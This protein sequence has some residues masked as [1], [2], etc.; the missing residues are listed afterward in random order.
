LTCEEANSCLGAA[1][2][3]SLEG[4]I[5]ESIRMNKKELY[6]YIYYSRSKGWWDSIRKENW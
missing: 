1:L 4:S 5:D 3:S 6:I 2:D